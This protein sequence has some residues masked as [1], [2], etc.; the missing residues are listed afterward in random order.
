MV[1]GFVVQNLSRQGERFV[2]A[3]GET[4]SVVY[5]IFFATAG[6]HLDVPL[7]QKLW[8]VALLLAGARALAT[9][10]AARIA[11][12]AAG[13]PPVVKRW[14]WA[15]LVSQAGLTLGL[16]AVVERTFPSFGTGF[17]S[18]AIATVALNE[19]VGPVLFK[20]ALDRSGESWKGPR[21]S[22]SSLS[23]PALG[24]ET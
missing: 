4:G 8:P 12:R 9:V 17:R 24:K 14:G 23:D 2:K 6:A 20:L 10:A 11:A 13:D 21:P 22:L 18:L 7:L 19:M 16:S 15:G 3:I 1:A 5:V